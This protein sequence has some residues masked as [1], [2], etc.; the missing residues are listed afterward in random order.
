MKY[1]E[2]YQRA[3]LS[4][5]ED[6]GV[7]SLKIPLEAYHS[8]RID[9]DLPNEEKQE[10]MEWYSLAR[11]SCVRGSQELILVSTKPTV[12]EG[13][14]FPLTS[15]FFSFQYDE[16]AIG[17]RERILCSAVDNGYIN[18]SSLDKSSGHNSLAYSTER[19]FGKMGVISLDEATAD[20]FAA[21]A[22]LYDHI[23]YTTKCAIENSRKEEIRLRKIAMRD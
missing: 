23:H 20:L 5:V 9:P 7:P 16:P 6:L 14:I 13:R 17:L 2:R 1:Q 22:A 10:L 11:A 4:L 18:G 8:K 19:I 3:V 15:N 12:Y 21:E